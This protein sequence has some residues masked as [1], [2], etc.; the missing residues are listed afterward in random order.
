MLVDQRGRL[1]DNVAGCSAE[2]LAEPCGV[3]EFRFH[4]A[5]FA[6]VCLSGAVASGKKHGRDDFE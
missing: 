4:H 6:A 2:K 1:L 3:E 5:S